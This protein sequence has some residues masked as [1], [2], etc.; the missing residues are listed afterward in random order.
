MGD[1]L[2]RFVS[3]N[4][5]EFDADVP[6]REIWAKIESVTSKKRS[7]SM[8]VWKVA[9][10]LLLISTIGLLLE[11]TGAYSEGSDE[12]TANLTEFQ[13]VETYY[14]SQIL[15]K[16]RELSNIQAGERK[17]EF[18][19]EIAELDHVYM[20]LKKMAQKQT[21]ESMLT[22]AMIANLQLRL[23]V[24]NQQLEVLKRY[25]NEKINEVGNVEI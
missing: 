24:L 14:I 2:E 15:D 12:M 8:N 20:E 3:E 4:R 21:S 18:L 5:E 6:S 17:S 19:N 23:E 9:A 22:D 11:R 25:K 13:Q 1:S 10:V 7:D 16:K